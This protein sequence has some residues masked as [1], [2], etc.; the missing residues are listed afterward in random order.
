MDKDN[1]KANKMVMKPSDPIPRQREKP[2]AE[3]LFRFRLVRGQFRNAAN[4]CRHRPCRYPNEVTVLHSRLLAA[5]IDA[6]NRVVPRKPFRPLLTGDG[7]VFSLQ[8][9]GGIHT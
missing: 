6:V 1:A 9:K 3:R 5:C 4:P 7:K 8:R 2:L